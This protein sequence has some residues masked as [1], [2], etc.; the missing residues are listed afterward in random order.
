[1]RRP[2]SLRVRL[3]AVSLSVLLGFVVLTGLALDRAFRDSADAAQQERLEALLYLL[4]GALEVGADGRLLMPAPLPEARLAT[5]ASGLYAEIVRAPAAP[6]ADVVP[7]TRWLSDSALGL[8]VPLGAVLAPGERISEVRAGDDGLAYRVLARGVRWAIGE[9]PS[10]ITFSVAA[11][12]ASTGTG[13]EAY[14]RSL[15]SALAVMAALLLVALV[16]VQHWGLRPLRRLARRLAAMEAGD[17]RDPGGP[18]PRELA[19]LARNLDRLLQRERTMLERHRKA[20]G[21]L[22]HALKTPLAILRTAPGQ[23]EPVQIVREQTQRMDAIVQYHLQRAATAGASQSAPPIAL[24]PLVARLCASIAK[25]HADRALTLDN[26]VPAELHARIDDGDAMELLGN[27]VDNAC[28]WATTT[29][30]VQ[31]TR[32]EGGLLLAVDDDGAGIAD[33]QRLMRRGLRGDERVPGHGMGLAIVNDIAL[34]YGGEVRIERS[35]LGGARIA[36][37]LAAC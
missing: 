33:P 19:P 25:V 36:V 1:M 10:L 21:D 23:P 24:A 18:Y 31:A 12:L 4:M 27:L 17:A 28:K 20:L 16:L 11:P 30:R 7:P 14:R 37:W 9:R 29:V 13:V 15:W 5:P 32:C 35:T 34:A 6:G 8:S 2:W 22:A 3:L 26:S